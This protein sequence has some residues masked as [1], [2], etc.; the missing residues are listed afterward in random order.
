[1]HP[2]LRKLLLQRISTLGVKSFCD[3]TVTEIRPRSVFIKTKSGHP[4]EQAAGT[5][6]LSVGCA[7]DSGLKEELQNQFNE[8]YEI[9]ECTGEAG[10]TKAIA[11]GARI[12]RAI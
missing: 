8:V 12:G 10:I 7:G 11:D 9:G 6:V 4:F 5:I 1:M 2:F 3:S